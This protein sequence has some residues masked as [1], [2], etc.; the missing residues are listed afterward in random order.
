MSHETPL[1]PPCSQAWNWQRF[2][3]LAVAHWAEQRRHYLGYLL[4]LAILYAVLL[5]L[6]LGVSSFKAFDAEVQAVF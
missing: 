4:V 2:A 3:C 1:A 6:T 5:L